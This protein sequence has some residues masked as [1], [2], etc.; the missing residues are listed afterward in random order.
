M[1]EN[2]PLEIKE[3]DSGLIQSEKDNPLGSP[4]TTTPAWLLKNPPAPIEPQTYE[5]HIK[6][7]WETVGTEYIPLESIDETL[8]DED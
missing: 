3:K 6:H 8:P 1:V 4:V 5:N 2:Q 7:L